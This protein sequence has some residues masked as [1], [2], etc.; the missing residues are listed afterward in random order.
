MQFHLIDLLSFYR[1]ESGLM[2]QLILFTVVTSVI[3]PKKQKNWKLLDEK[4]AIVVIGEPKNTV[5]LGTAMCWP[6]L[7]TSRKSRINCLWQ[8]KH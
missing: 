8:H 1:A 4:T 2:Q 3:P 7:P 5:A 6:A